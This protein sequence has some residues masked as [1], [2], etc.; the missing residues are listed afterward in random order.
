LASAG[1]I[2]ATEWTG[3]I[4]ATEWTDAE[5][6]AKRERSKD[7]DLARHLTIGYHG[8]WWTDEEL[9]LLGALP[10]AEVAAR[11]G[12]TA[13]AVRVKR[14]RGS[15]CSTRM[16]LGTTSGTCGWTIEA[17][18]SRPRLRPRGPNCRAVEAAAW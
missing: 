15:I 3:A 10:D 6:Q 4:R 5:R 16:I 18:Q 14:Q 17:A 1:A 8:P 9:A 11:I 7:L 2:R 12:R 13:N